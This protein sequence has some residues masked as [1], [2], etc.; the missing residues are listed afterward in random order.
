MTTI[1][2]N[3]HWR[4]ELD[5][6]S[7]Q[8]SKARQRKGAQRWQGVCWFPRLTQALH[9]LLER[10]IR[11]AD[12]ADTQEI[13]NAITSASQALTA[14][15]ERASIEDV[16]AAR[17]HRRTASAGQRMAGQVLLGAGGHR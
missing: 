3:D 6:H 16:A 17:S 12:L 10:G 13:I 9:W 11:G 1:P 2:V 4:I 8:I 7:W 15:V 14:A 5:S